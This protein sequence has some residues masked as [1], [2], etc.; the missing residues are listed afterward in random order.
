MSLKRN[1]VANY[2]SQIYISLL[3]LAVVP[4]YFSKMGP[5]A[6]GL[7]GFFGMLQGWLQLLDMGLSSTLSREVTCYRAGALSGERMTALLRTLALVF[8]VAGALSASVVCFASG[9]IANSWLHANALSPHLLASCISL[10]GIAAAL[11]WICGLYRGIISGWEEQVWLS[12]YNVAMAT[13]RYLGVLVV[14]AFVGVDPLSFFVFQLLVAVVELMLL[15]WKAG[16]LLPGAWAWPSL[17]LEP[18]Q[19][20]W[21]FSGALAFCTIIWV[22][23]IQTDKLVLSKTL[24]L[25][26]YGYF[27]LAIM[28]ANA[29]S[30]VSGPISAALLP[31][32]TFLF[33]Q[34]DREGFI[35]LYR[36]ATQWVSVVV[37]P[38]AGSIAFLAEPLLLVWTK[39]SFVAH[40]A[41]PVLFWYALGNACLGLG[42]FQF[43]MQYAHGKLRLHVIGNAV[44]ISVLIPSVLWASV[45]YGAVGA[46]RVWFAENLISLF[47]WTWIVHCRFSPGLYWKWLGRDVLPIAATALFVSWMLSSIVNSSA[48]RLHLTAQMGLVGSISL[49]VAALSS[50]VMLSKARRLFFERNLA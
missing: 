38:V 35:A 11:R 41:A 25:T 42:A 33:S 34:S 19:E 9:W 48:E 18:L 40:K 16:K 5:E 7:V 3:G 43:Y 27:T 8:I 31:R 26:D 21:R 32:L 15:W 47:V 22:F 39:D 23:V 20:M 46:A 24:N 36:N 6:Y 10:M 49:V 17:K 44:F 30:V 28:V 37:W 29:V 45:T 1:V 14:F 2:A 12:G 13:V 50:T 4:V